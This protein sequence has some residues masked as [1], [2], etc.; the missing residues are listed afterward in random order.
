VADLALEQGRDLFVVPASADTPQGAGMIT[1]M[2]QGC[3]PVTRGWE[4]LE[5]LHEQYGHLLHRKEPK[6]PA[7]VKKEA[8]AEVPQ[9]PEDW[10]EPPSQ[11]APA[12]KA[13]DNRE[14]LAYIDLDAQKNAYTDEERAILRALQSSP[15]TAD[16]LVADTGIPARRIFSALTILTI[17]QL[18]EE[19]DGGR[20][21]A[22]VR[23]NPA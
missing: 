8:P 13:V 16:D 23:V 7:P 3:A 10:K 17:R 1:L 9:I 20:Y 22:M 18:V 21:R 15:R 19:E 5:T 14:N 12:E 11:P 6:N 4:I 2:K